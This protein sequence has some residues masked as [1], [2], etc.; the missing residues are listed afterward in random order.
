MQP[1]ELNRILVT[2]GAAQTLQTDAQFL[3]HVT[4]PDIAW[5][6]AKYILRAGASAGLPIFIQDA[7]AERLLSFGEREFPVVMPLFRGGRIVTAVITG[8]KQGNLRG[9][10]SGDRAEIDITG[11]DIHATIEELQRLTTAAMCAEARKTLKTAGVPAE[12]LDTLCSETSPDALINTAALL[13]ALKPES[14]GGTLTQTL[15]DSPELAREMLRLR[16]ELLW[17]RPPN[18]IPIIAATITFS[19]NNEKPD[20]EEHHPSPVE[21]ALGLI[22][23]ERRDIWVVVIYSLIIGL[24][25]LATPLAVNSIVS[26]I[27]AGIFTLPIVVLSG[28]IFGGLLVAGL[29]SVIQRYAIEVIQQRIFVRTAFEVSHKLVHAKIESL[30][31]EYAPELLN[32]FFDIVTV[33]KGLSKLLLD[34]LS[35]ALVGIAGLSLLIVISPSLLSLGLLTVVISIIGV[36]LLGRGGLRTSIG[37]SKKKYE[38]AALLEDIGRCLVSFKLS[39]AP[40]YMYKR[41]DALLVQ[42]LLYRKSHFAVLIRQ[43]S[44][45][46]IVRAVVNTGVLAVGGLLVID[47][48]ISLGQLVATEIVIVMLVSSLDKLFSQ[49]EVVYDLLTALDK[50]GHITDLPQEKSD[51][52]I[53]PDRPKGMSVTCRNISYS[54]NQLSLLNHLD[55]TV[56]AGERVCLVGKSGTGKSTIAQ[57]LIGISTPKIGTILLDEFDSRSLELASM[58]RYIGLALPDD[59]I[60]DGTI[61][62]NIAL[63]RSWVTPQSVMEAIRLVRLDESFFRLPE[64]IYTNLISHGKNLSTGQIRRIM[65][66]RAIVHK[67]RLLILDES[68]GGIEENRKMDILHELYDPKHPWTILSITHDPEVVANSGRI[69]VLDNGNIAETGS[70]AELSRIESSRFA[71]LF[72]DLVRELRKDMPEFAHS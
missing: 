4:A 51:G 22:K 69:A 48:Q 21:R 41:L 30:R 44:G 52:T 23:L 50:V 27:S 3:E 29:L 35:A 60:F 12:R 20:D 13:S 9:M 2:L 37:K 57:L 55:L 67:P 46:T 8:A 62:D 63:G 61:Y 10:A 17:N 34:G 49:L 14:G 28:I 1:E 42:Y 11:N 38:V 25:T 68:F 43:L 72:P 66:C 36:Y 7:S 47:R 19:R 71:R 24:F 59:E 6:D 31:Q 15:L 40:S 58:R 70:P 5:S 53:L 54:Y 18:A 26:T 16:P 64:G 45:F 32:R 39:A 56:N 65:I 33:Q